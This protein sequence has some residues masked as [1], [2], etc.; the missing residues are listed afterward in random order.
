MP[1][2]TPAM[3]IVRILLPGNFVQFTLP[4]ERKEEMVKWL[5]NMAQCTDV[6]PY[7]ENGDTYVRGSAITGF[8][9]TDYIEPRGKTPQEEDLYLKRKILKILQD[10]LESGEEW[11]GAGGEE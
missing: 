5:T 8:Y 7:T 6:R 9:F 11:K 2:P 10:G 4:K 1:E 3:V